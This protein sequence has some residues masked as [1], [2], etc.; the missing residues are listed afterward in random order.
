LQIGIDGGWTLPQLKRLAYNYVQLESAYDLLMP[1][2]RRGNVNRYCRSNG[3]AATANWTR[4]KKDGLALVKRA[5]SIDE[6]KQLLCPDRYMKMNLRALDKHG[7]VE[8]RHAGGCQYPAKA[9]AFAVLWLQLAEASIDSSRPLARI[10]KK[11]YAFENLLAFCESS[12]V[13]VDWLN[14]SLS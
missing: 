13:L 3:A 10:P 8:F 14:R 4:S 1:F 2:S 6:L 11:G 5:T 12:P 9:V 7:T